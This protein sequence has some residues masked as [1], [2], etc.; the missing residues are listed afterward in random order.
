VGNDDGELVG[1]DEGET[2]GVAV[3][4]AEGL[5]LGDTLGEDEGETD[6]VAV[7]E[8]E[9]L[10]LGDTLGEADGS[11]LTV[12]DALGLADDTEDDKV[13]AGES[14]GLAV[15]LGPNVGRSVN[16]PEP[17]TGISIFGAAA[18]LFFP[19]FPVEL[20]LSR[21]YRTP[22]TT[23]E[24]AGRPPRFNVSAHQT[25]HAKRMASNSNLVILPPIM[26]V[27]N[28]IRG[29]YLFVMSSSSIRQRD[30]NDK[31]RGAL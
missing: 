16:A 17:A 21:R 14:L 19:P 8:A 7:G 30:C 13:G 27:K 1:E 5:L 15:A 25:S 20:L 9:G 11:L 10:L 23:I 29:S 2:D 26:S 28:E 3:G 22:L 6:G 18:G 12:G 24:S 31:K 4:E